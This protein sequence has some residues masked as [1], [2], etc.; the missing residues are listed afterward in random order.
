MLIVLLDDVG[1]GASSAFGGPVNMPTAERLAGEGLRYTRFHTTALCSPT[2]AA[3]LFGS[4]SP[5]RRHGRHHRDRDLGAGLQLGAPDTCSAA[6]ASSLKLNGYATA[7]VGKCHE[8]P[9]WETSPQPVRSTV[10]PAP[11]TGSSTSTASSGAK[12]MST[13]PGLHEGTAAVDPDRTPE[14]GY[15]LMEDLADRGIAWVRLE[16]GDE[17]ADW[18]IEASPGAAAWAWSTAPPSSASTGRSRS[19]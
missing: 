14:Q 16:P 9:V 1:F 12:P 8:V 3:L 5:H 15:H 19:S 7:H 11:A 6:G 13:T 18:R 10:G 4:Q 17:F 2:R